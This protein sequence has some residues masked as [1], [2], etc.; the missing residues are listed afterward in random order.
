MEN[1]VFTPGPLLYLFAVI[2]VLI[3]CFNIL[4]LPPLDGFRIT[5]LAVEKLRGRSF[6]QEHVEKVLIA[7]YV[8][9]ISLFI[10]VTIIDIGRLLQGKTLL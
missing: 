5:L 2:N 10:A 4:P 8:L 7:G 3:G 1:C 9:L 6:K